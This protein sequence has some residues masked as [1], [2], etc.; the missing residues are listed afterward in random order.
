M[1]I[2]E[3][4]NALKLNPDDGET[5]FYLARAYDL[6]SKPNDATQYYKRAVTWLLEFTRKHPESAYGYYLLGNAYFADNQRDKA[7]E[8][9]AKC[10]DLSPRFVRARYNVAIIQ[11]RQ[12]NKTAALEQ[13][14]RLLVLDPDLA[15]KLK[16]EIDKS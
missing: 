15:G 16:I 14:N 3:C 2:R 7:I 11:L 9:Y 6:A 8:A 1:A 4:N 12:K 5:Y 13:Y 10:L